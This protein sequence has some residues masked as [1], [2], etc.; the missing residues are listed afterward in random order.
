MLLKQG[1]REYSHSIS[2]SLDE[3]SISLGKSLKSFNRLPGLL[4]RSIIDANR[5][6]L[7]MSSGKLVKLP[8]DSASLTAPISRRG[9]LRRADS[10]LDPAGL[11]L[12]SAFEPPGESELAALYAPAIAFAFEES[13]AAALLLDIFALAGRGSSSGD[14]SEVSINPVPVA[15][16]EFELPIVGQTVPLLLSADVIPLA[17]VV[18]GDSRVVGMGA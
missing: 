12:R 16:G 10:L 15:I 18:L 6:A 1:S 14:E 9:G 11:G 2:L 8:L 5:V 7:R 3:R 17:R 13:R 4:P